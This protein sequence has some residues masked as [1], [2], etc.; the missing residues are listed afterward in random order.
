M[1]CNFTYLLHS[2]SRDGK[3]HSCTEKY[4]PILIGKKLVLKLHGTVYPIC[5]RCLTHGSET[6]ANEKEAWKTEPK[7]VCSYGCE[8]LNRK[9]GEEMPRSE[10]CWDQD[11]SVW[12]SRK[13][14]EDGMDMLNVRMMPVQFNGV[15]RWMLMEQD[16]MVIRGRLAGTVKK[17]MK[18][19]CLFREDTV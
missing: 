16:R 9:E 3:N 8:V 10:N 19:L 1:T 5:M 6:L 18:S 12:W 13:V 17:I 14:D 11:Q 2:F 4:L 7:Q 15:W